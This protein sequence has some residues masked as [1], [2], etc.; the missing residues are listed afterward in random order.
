MKRISLLFISV[1]LILTG[2]LSSCET[3]I[4]VTAE[5]K[6]ITVVYGIL[7]R[8][9]S[10][11]YFRINK[12]FLGD[13]NVLEYV[14]NADS[15][16]YYD[17]LEVTLTESNSSGPTRTLQFDTIQ[18]DNKEDGTFY[19]PKQV[20]Y[21]SEFKIPTGDQE[22]TYSLK[23]RNKITG[24]EITSKTSVV[25]NFD[26]T[27]PR[28]GQPT[29]D[30]LTDNNFVMKWRSGKN[31]RRYEPFIRFWF[32]EVFVGN[33]TIDRYIDWRLGSAK[34]KNLNGGEEMTMPYK[35]TGIYEISKS[36]IPYKDGREAQVIAR[37]VDRCDFTIAVAGDEL[38][39]YMEVNGPT[40]GITQDRPEYSNIDN[41]LGLFSSRYTK[42]ISIP[43]GAPTEARFMQ[44]EGL[45]FK[46]KL[47]N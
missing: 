47:G 28:F 30:F 38:N 7:S 1:S 18:I 24:K 12:A 34:S 42:M 41:G 45:K 16:S 17:N 3:D 10:I 46:D 8:N 26:I 19:G 21:K 35:P 5:Y 43:V 22:Y 4:D 40:S 11:H 32:Q 36:L 44:I 37:Y 2:L 25:K 20:A 13:G 23:V 6:D 14:T 27:S 39:T 31:G 15:S 9:D 29:I 33:D